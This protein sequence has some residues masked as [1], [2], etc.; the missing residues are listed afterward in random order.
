[1][2]FG[3]TPIEGITD[4]HFRFMIRLMSKETH[5]YTEPILAK[6]LLEKSLRD[7]ILKYNPEEHPLSLF[8]RGQDP[9]AMKEASII[10]EGYGYD[11]IHIKSFSPLERIGAGNF[12]VSIIPDPEIS[13]RCASAIVKSVKIPVSINIEISLVGDNFSE[14]ETL[15]LK[16]FI[17]LVSE[18]GVKEFV[19][20]IKRNHLKMEP[21]SLSKQNKIRHDMVYQLKRLHPEIKFVTYGD[22]KNF[23]SALIHLEKVDGTLIGKTVYSNPYMMIEAD[24]KIFGKKYPIPS[25]TKVVEDMIDYA[26]RTINEGGNSIKKIAKHMMGLFNSCEGSRLWKYMLVEGCNF[27]DAGSEVLVMALNK[28]EDKE[29]PYL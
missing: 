18:V 29:C 10:G 27:E 4:R 16:R 24:E 6:D 5:L 21:G 26:D 13:C 9:K 14:D 23:S 12:C 11:S 3:I 1:M 2:R 8:L 19:I 20:S 15:K 22:I 7:E 28:L 17:R 25:R